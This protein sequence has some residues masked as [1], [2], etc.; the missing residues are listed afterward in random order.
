MFAY[1]VRLHRDGYRSLPDCL[2]QTVAD[3][4]HKAFVETGHEYLH[5]ELFNNELL[6]KYDLT[7]I[8][9]SLVLVLLY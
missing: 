2:Q 9:S 8:R 3:A 6:R 4:V 7:R 1:V 5:N